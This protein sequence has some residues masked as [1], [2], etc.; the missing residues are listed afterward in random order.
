MIILYKYNAIQN[1]QYTGQCN[2]EI[3][4]SVKTIYIYSVLLPEFLYNHIVQF[5]VQYIYI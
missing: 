1:I 2:R 5:N 3:F 4:T